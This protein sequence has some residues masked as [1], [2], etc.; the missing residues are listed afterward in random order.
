M[1]RPSH[2][3]V[4]GG[5]SMSEIEKETVTATSDAEP[6]KKKGGMKFILIGVVLVLLLGGGGA[7]YYFLRIAGAQ[8][9]EE[10]EKKTDKKSAAKKASDEEDEPKAKKTGAL[11]DAIPDDEEVKKVIEVQPFIVNL[12]DAEQARYLRMT[13]SLGVGG[14][15]G[16]KEKPDTV[17]LTKVR[18]A[19]LAVLSEKTSEEILTVEGKAKLRKE[20]LKAAQASAA[21]PEIIAIYITDF[22]VQL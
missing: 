5:I 13:V 7:G 20:L 12:A 8:A 19:M 4:S 9:A 6:P 15:G 16:E 22:I 21:E 10:P 1:A 2:Y 14:E 3:I 17:F 11:A 18:N